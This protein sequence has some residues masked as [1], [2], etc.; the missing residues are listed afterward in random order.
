[1]HPGTILTSVVAIDALYFPD[2]HVGRQLE[3]AVVHRE[4]LKAYVGFGVDGAECSKARVPA[5][6]TGKWG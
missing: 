6:A 3:A 4:L 5:I 1:V 2:T